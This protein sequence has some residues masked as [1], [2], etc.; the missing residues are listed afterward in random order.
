MRTGLT[1]LV[2]GLLIWMMPAAAG[3]IAVGSMIIEKPW[4]RA[5]PKGARVGA[6]YFGLINIGTADDRLVSATSQVSD[7]VEIHTV[8]M[9]GGVMK[10]R[11]LTDGLVVKARGT[12]TLQPG[13][14]HLMLIGLKAPLQK[15]QDFNV[16]LT[17]EK[18]GDID[19]LFKTT[20]IGGAS[21]YPADDRV[22]GSAS[23]TALGSG[24]QSK[25]KRVK[26]GSH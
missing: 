7:R 17:F 10:M 8:S 19:V 15:D 25:T 3:D 11:R 4:A 6:G 16:K 13:G 5:T 20:G 23:G 21:P 22:S 1:T 26:R 18:A 2:F 24:T 14:H 12:V 9:D